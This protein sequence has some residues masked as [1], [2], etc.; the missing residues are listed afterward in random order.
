M[1]IRE[2]MQLFCTKF[3]GG[4]LRNYLTRRKDGHMGQHQGTKSEPSVEEPEVETK[5]A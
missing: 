3:S 2:G 1:R 5:G 4:S